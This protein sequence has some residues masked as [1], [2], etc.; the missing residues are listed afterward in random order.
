MQCNTW[1]KRAR[2]IDIDM[3]LLGRLFS[4]SRISIALVF[5]IGKEI[6]QI[7]IF[8]QL[9]KEKQ[10]LYFILTFTNFLTEMMDLG[11]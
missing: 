9:E 7:V 3:G 8:K 1:T 11:R 5:P 6:E 10:R 4:V 2:V